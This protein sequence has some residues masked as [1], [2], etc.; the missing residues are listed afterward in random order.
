ML[1]RFNVHEWI[2][3]TFN[4]S[5]SEVRLIHSSPDEGGARN[6]LELWIFSE[7]HTH[8]VACTYVMKMEMYVKSEMR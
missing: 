3:D 7:R 8:S 4:V 1:A 6:Q 2:Y 5:W